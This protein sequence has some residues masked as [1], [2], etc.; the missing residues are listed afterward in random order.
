MTAVQQHDGIGAVK[1]SAMYRALSNVAPVDILLN[2]VHTTPH[3]TVIT[4]A[5]V[6]LTTNVVLRNRKQLAQH[7]QRPTVAP[8]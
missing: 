2:D 6:T 8:E 1:L 5:N 3:R 7:H 4:D